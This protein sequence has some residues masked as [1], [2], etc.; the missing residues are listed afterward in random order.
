MIGAYAFVYFAMLYMKILV[1]LEHKNY[2]QNWM[3]TNYD[4]P[5]K[6]IDDK[7]EYPQEKRKRLLHGRL[8]LINPYSQLVHFS[9]LSKERRRKI[10]NNKTCYT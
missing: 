1:I 7:S 9:N 8:S 10:N 6:L 4:N 2:I 3:E 5:N